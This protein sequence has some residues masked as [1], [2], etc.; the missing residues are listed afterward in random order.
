MP[1]PLLK[2]PGLDFYRPTLDVPLHSEDVDTFGLVH[3]D[4]RP[5]N[6][7]NSGHGASIGG[8]LGTCQ[9]LWR[10]RGNRGRPRSWWLVDLFA[11]LQE[12]NGKAEGRYKSFG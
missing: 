12:P 8:D 2:A 7:K 9:R 11:L 4:R 6:R 10:E 5:S 1:S 3:R